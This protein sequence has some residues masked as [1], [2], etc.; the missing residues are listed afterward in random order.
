[1]RWTRQNVKRNPTEEDLE[2]DHIPARF[3]ITTEVRHGSVEQLRLWVEFEEA[4]YLQ[5]LELECLCTRQ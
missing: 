3:R 5:Q 2:L 4:N 1:M